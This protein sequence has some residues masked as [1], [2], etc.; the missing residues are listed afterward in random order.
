MEVKGL[1]L[2]W[3]SQKL[4]ETEAKLHRKEQEMARGQKETSMVEVEATGNAGEDRE[5]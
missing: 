3:E 2:V 4:R 5:R 1:Q